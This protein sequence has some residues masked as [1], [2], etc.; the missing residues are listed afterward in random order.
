MGAD[1]SRGHRTFCYM[2]ECS[3]HEV[4]RRGRAWRAMLE[5]GVEAGVLAGVLK[6]GVVCRWGCGGWRLRCACVSRASAS[7]IK[8]AP[9]ATLLVVPCSPVLS[10]R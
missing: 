2:R 10:V 8:V 5:S 9:N 6:S 4:G 7:A 1:V 3:P